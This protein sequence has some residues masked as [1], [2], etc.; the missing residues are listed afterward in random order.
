MVMLGSVIHTWLIVNLDAIG[1]IGCC[2]V[3]LSWWAYRQCE[4]RCADCGYCP[5]WCQ[6]ERH[7]D[8]GHHAHRD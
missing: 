5:I 3:L 6:C 1:G 2:V 7:D 4:S 8:G